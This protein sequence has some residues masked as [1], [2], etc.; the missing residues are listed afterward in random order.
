MR[1][2][3]DRPPLG[4]GPGPGGP[5]GAGLGHALPAEAGE[6]AGAG[7]EAS[8][9]CVPATGRPGYRLPRSTR[10]RSLP[11][12]LGPPQARRGLTGEAR[13][14]RASIP[15][16][17]LARPA[18][19]PQ[20]E[21]SRT[22]DSGVAVGPGDL[23]QVPSPLWLQRAFLLMGTSPTRRGKGIMGGGGAHGSGAHGAVRLLSTPVRCKPC[24]PQRRCL[25]AG[26]LSGSSPSSETV[27]CAWNCKVQHSSHEATRGC[28][29]LS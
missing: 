24:R 21:S 16:A 18:E 29:C 3:G 20:A 14:T 1:R 12:G 7:G 4:Q 9:P 15:R 23:K 10:I 8:A 6:Q 27:P 19:A 2:R 22:L 26:L 17:R 28:F 11:E 13:S 25:K 5:T